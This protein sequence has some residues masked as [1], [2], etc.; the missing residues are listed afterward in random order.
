MFVLVF[1]AKAERNTPGRI[2]VEL[3]ARDQDAA[4]HAIS[5]AKE[6][7]PEGYALGVSEIHP[8]KNRTGSGSNGRRRKVS[9]AYIRTEEG[10]DRTSIDTLRENFAPLWRASLSRDHLQPIHQDDARRVDPTS[11]AKS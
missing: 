2:R 1:H 4:G 6:L 3:R 5:L 9:V 10:R 7:T 11:S 8:E